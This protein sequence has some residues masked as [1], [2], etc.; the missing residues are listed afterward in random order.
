M[1]TLLLTI[2]FIN[3]LV[4]P[5][6]KIA[7]A[8]QYVLD[9]SVLPKVNDVI[10]LARKNHLL[11][12]HVKVGFSFDYIQCPKKSPVFS[13]APELGALKLGE[14][15]TEFHESLKINASDAIIIKHRVSA[16]YATSLATILSANSIQQVIIAG[17]S[18]NMAVETVARELHDRDYSVIIVEDACAAANRE[19]HEASLV[20]LRRIATVCNIENL[21]SILITQNH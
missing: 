20:S 5:K 8:A 3:D 10:A 18:T 6:G 4:H 15:G 1:K 2:D 9:Y 19:I 11:I 7:S 12:A 21:P 13:K 16:L 17:V 14:W